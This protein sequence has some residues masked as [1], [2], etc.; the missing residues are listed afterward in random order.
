MSTVDGNQSLNSI[1]DKLGIQPQEEKS[2]LTAGL[3]DR[4]I[5]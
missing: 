1:L 2:A 4:K 5:F 3:W